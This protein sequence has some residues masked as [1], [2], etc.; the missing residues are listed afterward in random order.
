MSSYFF[1]RGLSLTFAVGA[2]VNAALV[3]PIVISATKVEMVFPNATRE[4]NN[5]TKYSQSMTFWR[6]FWAGP[7]I[8][9]RAKNRHKERRIVAIVKLLE[10]QM[11]VLAGIFGS[12]LN[13][14]VGGRR[15]TGIVVTVQREEKR[16]GDE[17]WAVR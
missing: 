13:S 14:P 16:D 1:G 11:R 9:R 12:R 4:V 5:E 8:R 10:S 2:A 15:I 6:A 3:D 17:R 7:R